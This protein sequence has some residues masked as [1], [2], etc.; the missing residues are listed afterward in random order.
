MDRNDVDLSLYKHVM[1]DTET[2]STSPVAVMRSVGVVV[3]NL[4]GIPE[5]QA[6]M[7]M[8]VSIEDQLMI[9]SVIDQSTVNF[10]REQ[11]AYKR[12]RLLGTSQVDLQIVLDRLQDVVIFMSDPCVWGHGSCFDIP[13]LQ[14]AYRAS[15]R[16]EPW[17]YKNVRDT[18]TLFALAGH[19]YKAKG[20]HDALDDAMNQALAVISAYAKLKGGVM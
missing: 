13:I 19:E 11:E 1:V 9:G 15:G 12:K 5:P 10:W 20:G 6:V 4:D 7:H 8:G 3:F 14:N 16:K 2:Y 18:R 17:V